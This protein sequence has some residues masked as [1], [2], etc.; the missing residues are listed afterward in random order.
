MAGQLAQSFPQVLFRAYDS[1]RGIDSSIE[2]YQ[3]SLTA[4]WLVFNGFGMRWPLLG[5]AVSFW[6]VGPVLDDVLVFDF[7]TER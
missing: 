2:N 1:R 6:L 4:S 3:L 5:S 7:Y